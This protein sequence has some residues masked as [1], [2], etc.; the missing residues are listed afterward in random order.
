MRYRD[1]LLAETP[2]YDA[3][4]LGW[5]V[6]PNPRQPAA[7]HFGDFVIKRPDGDVHG[8]AP[9]EE[10]GWRLANRWVR[11][12]DRE[13][14]GLPWDRDQYPEEDTYTREEEQELGAT[15]A[16]SRFRYYD[17]NGIG[18]RVM[19]HDPAKHVPERP[20]AVVI[21]PGDMIIHSMGMH[22][23]HPDDREAFRNSIRWAN[24]NQEGMRKELMVL[25]R[26]G[27]DFVVLH[28]ESSV[29][30]PEN[31]H[32]DHTKKVW[33][34]LQ[35]GAKRGSMVFGDDLERAGQW[36]INH[37]HIAERP[38]VFMLGAYSDPNN[39]CLTHIGKQFAKVLDPKKITVSKFSPV[40]DDPSE[41]HKVWQPGRQLI[42][43]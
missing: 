39:G 42:D 21:H 16:A 40:S 34:E 36:M 12:E 28:R 33:L 18:F 4:A 3:R 5:T 22:M 32:K 38:H 9:S 43:A 31:L 2:Q 30:F 27:Y 17:R 11:I 10:Q 26:Q 7:V 29:Q 8:H 19:D 23:L 14:K 25:K 15:K 13:A 41:Q 24:E 1:I 6:T 35:A 20:L 37:L